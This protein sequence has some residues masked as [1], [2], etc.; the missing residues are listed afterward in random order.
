[1]SA[2]LAAR[3]RDLMPG[4]VADLVRLAEIPS[5]AF[6]GYPREPLQAAHDLVAD[7]LRDAGVPTVETLHLPDTAPIVV[8]E[9][10]PPPGAPTVLLYAHYDVQPP[11]DLAL[12]DLKE[13]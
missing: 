1:M 4:L 6:P 5:I 3:A 8:G 12:W 11:G 13:I 2:D 10:P 7:L 9:I